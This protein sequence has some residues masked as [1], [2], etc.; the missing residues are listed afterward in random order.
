MS[1]RSSLRKRAFLA[2]GEPA[3]KA[4]AIFLARDPL[5]IAASR[6]RYFDADW[7]AHTHGLPSPRAAW[8]HFVMDGHAAGLAPMSCLA[9]EDGRTLSQLGAEL[10]Y[11]MGFA[12]GRSSSRPLLPAD[13]T[14]VRASAIDSSGN[15]R[16]AVVSALFGD[17]KRLLPT[18]PA[19]MA[20]ADFWLFTDRRFEDSGAWRAVHAPY[21]HVDPERRAA[22][23]KTHVPTWFGHYEAVLWVAPDVLMAAD[24][25][26]VVT[27]AGK[28]DAALRAFPAE[29]PCSVVAAA[30]RRAIARD[31]EMED[32]VAH[33]H[34]VADH[35]EARAP[36]R[37]ASDVL[38]MRPRADRLEALCDR[39]W[40]YILHGSASDALS[41]SLALAD[42]PDLNHG[43]IALAPLSASGEFARCG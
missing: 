3:S 40:R 18:D 42:T 5:S 19:W 31:E 30:A 28:S 11:R 14:A 12:V 20:S 23:Y 9:G 1:L 36:M 22:F 27:R 15:A 41:L 39:W 35:P 38:L 33:L 29:R 4:I 25:A 2:T 32:L 6:K 26:S 21:H 43:A 17:D 16:L 7:Y 24:P 13:P 10:L 8:Q 37:Y 34:A